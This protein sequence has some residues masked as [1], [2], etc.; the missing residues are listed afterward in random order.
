MMHEYDGLWWV[1][2]ENRAH[3][4][5]WRLMVVDPDGSHITVVY[6]SLWCDRHPIAYFSEC[7]DGPDCVWARTRRKR[8]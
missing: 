1:Q 2:Y 5:E 4:R 3:P 8:P 6:P 7:I